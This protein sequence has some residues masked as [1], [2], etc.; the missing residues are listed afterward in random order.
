MRKEVD[1]ATD[2]AERSGF[3]EALD[4]L[5]GIYAD[6]PAEKPLWFREGASSVVDTHERPEG[7]GVWSDKK[8]ENR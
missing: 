6:P 3:P 1:D 5:T 8:T 2:V 7:W 4:A